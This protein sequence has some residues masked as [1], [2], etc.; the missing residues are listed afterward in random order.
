MAEIANA[1]S[2]QDSGIPRPILDRTGLT[3]KYD[4]YIVFTPN[5]PNYSPEYLRK[6]R[7][8]TL[9]EALRDQLGLKL[10]ATT[11]QVDVLVVDRIEKP[12][13]N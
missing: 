5:S 7:G 8:P 11:G 3:G 9:E 12:T 4:F 10:E 6:M 2:Q 1:L 13:L